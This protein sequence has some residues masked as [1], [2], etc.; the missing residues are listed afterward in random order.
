MQL[1][2]GQRTTLASWGWLGWLV[3][4]LRTVTEHLRSDTADSTWR[5]RQ[6]GAKAADSV[7]F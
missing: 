5:C 6:A 4:A 2:P 3:A 1:Q 7:A